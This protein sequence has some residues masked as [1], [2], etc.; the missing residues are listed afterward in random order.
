M[1]RARWP[2]CRHLGWMQRGDG[3]T[4][5]RYGRLG[6]SGVAVW[7][8]CCTQPWLLSRTQSRAAKS[9]WRKPRAWS[10][11]WP[12]GGTRSSSSGLAC[13]A[14]GSWATLQW[15]VSEIDPTLAAVADAADAARRFE[16]AG[17]DA[18]GT[19][20][21]SGGRPLREAV[22][23]DEDVRKSAAP[24]TEVVAPAPY[25]DLDSYLE[26]ALYPTRPVPMALSGAPGVRREQGLA[27]PHRALVAH[28][29]GVPLVGAMERLSQGDLF[30][31]LDRLVPRRSQLQSLGGTCMQRDVFN[32]VA[33][34]VA[35]SSS[36]ALLARR[37]ID[38]RIAEVDESPTPWLHLA[39]W[40]ELQEDAEGAASCR[41][42]ASAL[43]NERAKSM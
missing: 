11:S 25:P 21:G 12:R 30:G 39:H 7:G 6:R 5:P 4:C 35:L 3:K 41:S 8:P 16:E 13:A 38:E 42:K 28:N 32:V 18:S 37:L 31:C 34:D 33:V 15:P 23:G 24:V 22:L 43:G 36:D 10:R 20:G 40:F 27:A 9:E 19:G 29:V 1:P 26:A 14:A 2:G 17:G